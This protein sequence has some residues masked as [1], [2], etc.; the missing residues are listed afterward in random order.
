MTSITS[1]CCICRTEEN[2]PIKFVWWAPTSI[3]GTLLVSLGSPEKCSFMNNDGWIH[4][5]IRSL[6]YD[7]MTSS[8]KPHT[9]SL[10]SSNQIIME[11]S[12]TIKSL[13]SE[14]NSIASHS[15]DDFLENQESRAKLVHCSRKLAVAVEDPGNVVFQTALLVS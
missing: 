7:Y 1:S 4:A 8:L 14:I 15:N 3:S 6:L 9:A 13:I 2:D 11:R 12:Q 10:V 5:N